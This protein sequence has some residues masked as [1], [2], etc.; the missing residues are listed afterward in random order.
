MGI[1]GRLK[2][3]R[4]AVSVGLTQTQ[5]RPWACVAVNSVMQLEGMDALHLCKFP[6]AS[7]IDCMQFR[8]GEFDNWTLF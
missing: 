8:F 3:V 2:D 4:L 7:Y 1:I 5:T 6:S